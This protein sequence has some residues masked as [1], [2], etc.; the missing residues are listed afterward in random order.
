MRWKISR[1]DLC[2]SLSVSKPNSTKTPFMSPAGFPQ[3]CEVGVMMEVECSFT[4]MET[5]HRVG[6]PV[7]YKL[8]TEG[9][10]TC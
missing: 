7:I 10:F 8:V 9:M 4:L 5:F 3:G 2:V 1:V 6:M